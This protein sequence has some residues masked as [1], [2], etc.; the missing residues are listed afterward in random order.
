MSGR[1]FQ[2]VLIGFTW[3][4]ISD[5]QEKQKQFTNDNYYYAPKSE[6]ITIQNEI[7]I[8]NKKISF[9]SY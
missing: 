7:N 1:F 3:R 4:A 5:F 9:E 6:L 8:L 2:F